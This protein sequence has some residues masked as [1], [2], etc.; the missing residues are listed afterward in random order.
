MMNSRFEEDRDPFLIDLSLEGKSQQAVESL[1][2][3]RCLRRVF[4][5]AELGDNMLHEL[6]HYL[7]E[8]RVEKL[9][10]GDIRYSTLVS[11]EHRKF[12][13]IS[14]GVFFFDIHT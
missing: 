6:W 8:G 13:L 12:P 14:I 5:H 4:E 2:H 7:I 11:S 10:H 9:P 1:K 3:N